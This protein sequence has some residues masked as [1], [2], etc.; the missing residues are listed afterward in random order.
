VVSIRPADDQ[1][2]ITQAVDGFFR[3]AVPYRC[4][5]RW[6]PSVPEMVIASSRVSAESP[7]SERCFRVLQADGIQLFEQCGT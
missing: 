5:T 4:P 6:F 7:A 1:T 2:V 3:E